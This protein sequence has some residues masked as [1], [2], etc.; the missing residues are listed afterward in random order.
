MNEIS[1]VVP[2]YRNRDMLACQVRTWRDYPPGLRMIVVDDG[3]P[4]PALEV[5]MNTASADQLDRIRVYRIGV[6][7]P[8]NRSG[9]RNLGTTVAETDWILHIDIDHVLPVDAAALLVDAPLSEACWYRFPRYRIGAA[10]ETRRKDS[11]APDEQYGKI[12]PHG[13]SYLVH[14]HR[15]WAAGG[16][17]ENFSGCLGGGSPFLQQLGA[18]AQLRMLLEPIRLH[19]YT[20]HVVKDASD[21]TLSRDTSGYSRRRRQMERDG[22]LRGANP[23][24]FPWARHL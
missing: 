2:F 23:L 14:K 7:I 16:Y 15:Y 24:R 4:E 12:K 11:L 19:V 5:V 8:W 1:V 13:D 6:D 18:V 9:A 17:N 20:R 10:D 3:S 21:L 22:T